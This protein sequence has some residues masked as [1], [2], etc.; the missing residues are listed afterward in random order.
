MTGMENL[1]IGLFAAGRGACEYINH[2]H[3]VEIVAVFDN[4]KHRWGEMFYGFEILPPQSISERK[5]DYL[6]ITTPYYEEEIRSGLIDNFPALTE[7]ICS[8]SKMNYL[9]Y[10][11]REYR[12]RYHEKNKQQY[13]VENKKI[14]IYTGI[15]GNYDTLLPPLYKDEAVD[16]ICYTDDENLVSSDW[17]IRYVECEQENSA[18]EV[19]KYKCLPHKFLPEYD[20]SVWIDAN[21]QIQSSILS[22]IRENMRDTG[23][24]FFT[25]YE[26]NCI[27]EE[28][29]INILLHKENTGKIIEQMYEYNQKRYPEHNGLFCGNF[30]VREHNRQTVAAIMEAWYA[31]LLKHSL[32]DQLSLPY[33][34]W[35][36]EIKPDV[37]WGYVNDNKYVKVYE[38]AY[39][40]TQS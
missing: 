25:H 27:Y 1:R 19:R 21:I 24:L 3:D 39:L 38:H 14:V 10:T 16:F 34:L 15:F 18:L 29:A 9:E 13:S 2:N 23:M 32:R 40:R 22:Y 26:R 31:E 12:K 37:C 35:K 36:N 20:I 4:D 17:E 11:Y 33:V 28:G 30:I 7:R 8:V 5:F 6:V